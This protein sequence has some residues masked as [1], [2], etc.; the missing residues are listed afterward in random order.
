VTRQ[1]LLAVPPSG[2][3]KDSCR[4]RGELARWV[5]T[6]T[7]LFLA[8]A[9]FFAL[10]VATGIEWFFAPDILLPIVGGMWIS[11]LAITSDTQATSAKSDVPE[12]VL[13]AEVRLEEPPLREAA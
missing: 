12:W 4:P 11:Y 5:M 10:A 1:Q 13:R 7:S 6:L 2:R 9:G 3:D 8:A